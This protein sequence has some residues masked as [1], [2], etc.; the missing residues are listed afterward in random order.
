MKDSENRTYY[1]LKLPN[2]VTAKKVQI[3]LARYLAGG[4]Y[5]L[6]TVAEVYFY[7][8]D[9]LRDEI[10]A[11]YADDLHTVLKED[12]TQETIDALRTKVN[13]PDEFGEEN[14]N[15]TLL[16]KELD[17]AEKILKDE[18]LN[19]P[20]EIHNGIT[21]NDTNRGFSGLNAWQPLGVAAEAGEKLTVYV[22]H[23]TKKT[24]E[25]T[26]L[27][28]VATQ[29]HAESNALSS[30]VTTLKVGANEITVPKIG[31]STGIEAGGA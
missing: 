20:V 24:G 22:G 15:K 8:Y 18:R 1:M 14:P 10:M 7:H 5:N 25:S 30:V 21:T 2:A 31:T 6:I 28:L 9:T 4:S 26:N 27:Q 23:N 16:L 17:T 19:D 29:Y 13:T 11:L 12:V 3:G